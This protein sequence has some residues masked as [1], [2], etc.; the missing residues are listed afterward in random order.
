MMSRNVL[1]FARPMA[2]SEPLRERCAVRL[3]EALRETAEKMYADA[4][5]AGDDALFDRAEKAINATQQS[6]FFDTMRRL[7]LAKPDLAARALSACKQE[8]ETCLRLGRNARTAGKPSLDDLSLVDPDTI[9]SD[10]AINTAAGKARSKF[11]REWQQLETRVDAI[12]AGTAEGESSG[13]RFGPE[14]FAEAFGKALGHFDCTIEVRLTLLKFMERELVTHSENLIAAAHQALTDCGVAPPTTAVPAFRPLRAAAS[15]ASAPASAALPANLAAA[16]QPSGPAA[17]A[18]LG[19]GELD[20]SFGASLQDF[21]AQLAAPMPPM[22]GAGHAGS[23]GF[24]PASGAPPVEAGMHDVMR[25]LAALDQKFRSLDRQAPTGGDVANALRE[26]IAQSSGNNAQLRPLDAGVI[27]LISLMFE[28]AVNDKHLP[29]ALQAS[30]ARLQIPYLKLAL[31]DP[32]FLARRDHPARR[33]LDELSQAAVGWTEASDRGLRQQVDAIVAALVDGFKDDTAVFERQREVLAAF[34]RKDGSRTEIAEKRAVQAADG[35]SKM[36]AAQR[37]AAAILKQKLD[38]TML[39][40]A[41]SSMVRDRWSNYLVLTLLR[42]GQDST[43]WSEAIRLLELIARFPRADAAL[44]ERAE[45][46]RELDDVSPIMR[47]GLAA[48]GVHDEDIDE[49]FAGLQE[50]LHL[51]SPDAPTAEAGTPVPVFTDAIRRQPPPI[52][53]EPVVID[54]P[55]T[56]PAA[57]PADE[58]AAELEEIQRLVAGTWIDMELSPG[59]R[60][61]VKLLWVSADRRNFLFVNANGIKV[62]DRKTRELAED[63]KAGRITILD[64]KPLVER[65]FEAAMARVRQFRA[66]SRKG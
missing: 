5:Q 47:K 60:E 8:I 59:R 33:L 6:D 55:P 36:E 9:E 58:L 38:G 23:V 39:P 24:G 19:A 30:I 51:P 46:R 43:A 65:A 14:L 40:K 56:E 22:P 27:D 42:H 61:R 7:R 18:P 54:L 37:D 25:A 2:D 32:Q 17:Y 52:P 63:L 11:A 41:L 45:W 34:L 57:A 31:I 26:Q 64:R 4:L 3:M 21:L 44:D 35:K 62:A 15:P 49:V 13:R 16:P 50:L 1:P 66:E 29:E 28:Y 12:F 10:I 20:P 53:V 48:T